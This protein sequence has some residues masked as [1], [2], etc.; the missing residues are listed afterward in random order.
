MNNRV[1]VKVSE[2]KTYGDKPTGF[3]ESAKK[4]K[5]KAEKRFSIR[6]S[7]VTRINQEWCIWIQRNAT[8]CKNNTITFRFPINRTMKLHYTN[9]SGFLELLLSQIENLQFCLR[10]KAEIEIFYSS[11]YPLIPDVILLTEKSVNPGSTSK[12]PSVSIEPSKSVS[13]SISKSESMSMPII[14][15]TNCNTNKIEK[16][17][18]IVQKTCSSNLSSCHQFPKKIKFILL[19]LLRI[20]DLLSQ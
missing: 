7:F 14:L 2:S 13:K 9:I 4:S 20:Y 18:A 8:I 1:Y 10:F 19:S 16:I 15:L 3:H 5:V 11:F 17:T 12:C 6:N